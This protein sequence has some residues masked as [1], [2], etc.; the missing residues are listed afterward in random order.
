VHDGRF[1]GRVLGDGELGFGE[2]YMDGDWDSDRLDELAT[3]IFSADIDKIA[4]HPIDLVNGC[5]GTP[6]LTAD[7]AAVSQSCGAA[8]HLGNDL[9]E[10]MLDTPY[11]AYTCAY[12]RGGAQTLEEAQEAKTRSGV[13]QAHAR[14]RHAR[15]R[16]WL[17]VGRSRQ[18]CGRALRSVRHRSDAP[19]REQAALGSARAAGL[20]VELLVQDYRDV[21]GTFE[22]CGLHRMSG[23]ISVIGITA[24]FSKSCPRATGRRRL[25][26]RAFDRL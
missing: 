22:S 8:L 14:A 2:S 16:H 12:W 21:T 23:S 4:W 26:P 18:V 6:R 24:V 3:R 13:P 15:A 5:N 1:F 20:P 7:T 9:F 17:R 19:P 11:M 10:A 25:R